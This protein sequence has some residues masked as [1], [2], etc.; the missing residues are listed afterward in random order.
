MV[1]PL[2]SHFYSEPTR[3]HDLRQL[4]PE[5]DG[6]YR[7]Y[8]D[9]AKFGVVN[10][11]KFKSAKERL[12]AEDDLPHAPR[13]P[14][15]VVTV[16]DAKFR[17][18]KERLTAV[19]DLRH[20]QSA[21]V[22]SDKKKDTRKRSSMS[23]RIVNSLWS[24]NTSDESLQKE[25]SNMTISDSAFLGELKGIQ[26]KDLAAPIHEAMA[27]D[28]TLLSSLIDSSVSA[29]TYAVLEMRQKEWKSRVELEVST[30]ERGALDGML[31]EF[32]RCINLRSTASGRRTS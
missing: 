12:T 4:Y 5:F 9:E 14:L 3:V 2:S 13:A 20:T 7:H 10:N 26:D 30:E 28:H 31:V 29:M 25:V 32:I 1:F 8:V 24:K 6:I 18:A 22:K 17:S 19:G 15:G 27:L 21:S 16:S 23:K 11:A